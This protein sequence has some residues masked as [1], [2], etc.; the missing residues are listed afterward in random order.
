MVVYRGVDP[1]KIYFLTWEKSF[2]EILKTIDKFNSQKY[3]FYM[4]MWRS[5]FQG[6]KGESGPFGSKG[7]PGDLVCPNLFHGL[8]KLFLKFPWHPEK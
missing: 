2:K 7:E 5:L 4:E 6:S 3:L 1:D 8:L